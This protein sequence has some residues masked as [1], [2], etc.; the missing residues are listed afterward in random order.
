MDYTNIKNTILLDSGYYRHC[1]NSKLFPHI[2]PLSL[3]GQVLEGDHLQVVT[4]VAH[5]DND[6]PKCE[7]IWV[8]IERILYSDWQPGIGYTFDCT[9]WSDPTFNTDI[10]R[11]D[12]IMVRPHNIFDIDFPKRSAEIDAEEAGK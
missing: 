5:I 7:A 6:N 4:L 12:R 1:V 11:G 9:V 3:I 8:R 10:E 2:P